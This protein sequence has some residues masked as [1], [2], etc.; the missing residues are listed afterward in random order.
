MADHGSH[1]GPSYSKSEASQNLEN[2]AGNKA[3]VASR[4]LK[5]PHFLFHERNFDDFSTPSFEPPTPPVQ[6]TVQGFVP[7]RR[8]GQEIDTGTLLSKLQNNCRLLVYFF[9]FLFA[10]T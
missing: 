10:E 6:S 7:E 4:N 5:L 3:H 1:L 8:Y 9:F 2:S